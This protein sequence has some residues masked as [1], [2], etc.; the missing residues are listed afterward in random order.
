MRRRRPEPA[1]LAGLL[2]VWA[3]AW[4][5]TPGRIAEDT[6]NDLYVD[7]WGFLARALHLWDPQV[8]W[9]GLSNQG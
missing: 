1:T 2:V 5:V 6:K 9:G 3:V 8:T 4:S 7:P